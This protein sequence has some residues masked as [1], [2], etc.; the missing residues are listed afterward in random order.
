MFVCVFASNMTIFREN[1]YIY[2][3]ETFDIEGQ[4]NWGHVTKFWPKLDQTPDELAKN[5]FK[6]EYDRFAL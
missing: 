5:T 6:T 1:G 2:R 4:W 3:L